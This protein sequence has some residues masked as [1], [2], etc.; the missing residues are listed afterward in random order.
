MIWIKKTRCVGQPGDAATFA[1]IASAIMFI[2]MA[3]TINASR[4]VDEIVEEIAGRV[5]V[6]LPH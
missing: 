4:T 1:Q 3:A 2:S 6:M 5:R